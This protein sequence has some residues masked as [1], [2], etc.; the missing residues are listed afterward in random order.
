MFSKLHHSN[1]SMEFFPPGHA[2]VDGKVEGIGEADEHV[3]EEDDLV[4]YLVV[5]ELHQAEICYFGLIYSIL[6]PSFSRAKPFSTETSL[7]YSYLDEIMCR[8]PRTER[9]ISTV[10]KTAM[11]TIS[12]NVVEFASLCLLSWFSLDRPPKM[13]SLFRSKRLF[14]PPPPDCF[15]LLMV[16]LRL[17]CSALLMAEKRR[18]LRMT[19]EMQGSS[20]TKRQRNL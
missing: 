9:G 17:L 3:D 13:E 15:L 11:T 19:R 18:M 4:R 16:S 10:R 2:T 5:K 12:I 7:F 20:W 14:P 1:F 8:R 6:H